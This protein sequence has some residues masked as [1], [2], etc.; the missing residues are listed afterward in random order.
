MESKSNINSKRVGLAIIFVVVVL[1][2]VFFLPKDSGKYGNLDE[3]ARCLGEKG[4]VMYGAYWCGHCQ[5]QKKAFG[6]SFRH[7][8]YVECTEDPKSCELAGIEG[9]PT[10]KIAS[11]TIVG[12][13]PLER[14]AEVSGCVLD[15]KN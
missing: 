14:L 10:W 2:T 1:S 6:Q 9:Y 4:A 3:F 13:V 12:E 5:N 11:T 7:I 15:I 8:K